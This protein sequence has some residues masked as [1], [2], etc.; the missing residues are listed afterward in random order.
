M[1]KVYD[2]RTFNVR[3]YSESALPTTVR[4]YVDGEAVPLNGNGGTEYFGLVPA[5]VHKLQ[6]GE[7]TG[8]Y[9]VKIGG[10]TVF[11]QSYVTRNELEY[12]ITG[13]VEID[14]RYED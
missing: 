2:R 7:S 5:G 11:G 4:L 8:F 3:I 14:M 10:S 6:A 9:S 1:S 12:A 13:N